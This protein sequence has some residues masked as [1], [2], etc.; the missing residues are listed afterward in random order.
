[1]NFRSV[2]LLWLLAIV[3]FA[4]AFFLARERVRMR[5][6]RRLVSERLRG[7]G[8]PTRP[9][10]PWLLA[11]AL[12]GAIV[13]L[14]GPYAGF[15]LVPVVAR[16]TN[17]VLV[18]DVSNSMSAEDV[19]PSRLGAARGVAKRLA[20]GQPGRLALVV[21]EGSAEVI[22]P[23]TSDTD[24]VVALIDTLQAGEV[25][26]AGS[27]LGGAILAALRL[28][29]ADPAQKADLVLLSDG[30]EQ[31]VRV[32]DAVQRARAHGVEVSTVMVGTAAGSTIPTP[33]GPLRDS[34]G[35]IVTTYARDEV[36]RDIAR[37]TGGTM[38]ENPFSADAIAPLVR[39]ASGGR[40]QETHARVPI[41]RYQWPLGLA[42]FAL[43]IGSLA[44]RGAE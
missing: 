32:K 34:S 18:I 33:R 23:M 41:D 1:M 7:A 19:S 38:L 9:I 14:A 29:E 12:A 2:S 3:P 35:D 8:N 30:E 6:A 40:K 4:L 13:A 25:G 39:H 26:E 16:E 20:E 44:N 27:D 17:R 36:L 28:I 22:S 21:F 31:G 11:V 24:A 42:F 15:T 5:I 43:L 37:Q 10:R